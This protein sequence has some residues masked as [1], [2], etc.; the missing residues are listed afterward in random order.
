MQLIGTR[1]DGKLLYILC[2]AV[3]RFGKVFD[4]KDNDSRVA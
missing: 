2:V 1:P 3:T 4:Q